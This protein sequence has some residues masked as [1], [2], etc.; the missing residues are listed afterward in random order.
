[1]IVN[2]IRFLNQPTNTNRQLVAIDITYNDIDY[3]W[4]IYAPLVSG[5]AMNDYITAVTNI[6]TADIDRKES[7][8]VDYPK[9]EEIQDPFM[10]DPQIVDIPKER[11]VHPTIPDYVEGIARGYTQEQLDSISDELGSDYWHYPQY[12]KRIVAP[13]ELILDDIGIKMYGW[14]QLN[15]FPIIKMGQSVN[16]Y[17]NTILPEHQ[18][19]VN[20]LQGIIIIEDRP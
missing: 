18:E 7:I 12:V 15:N 1:M 14:F 6:I 13:I 2:D 10:G 11:V 8:W 9:T 3:N 17:C 5:E 19:I 20:Q 4:T 16:L